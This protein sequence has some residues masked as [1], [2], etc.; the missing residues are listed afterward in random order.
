GGVGDAVGAQGVEEDLVVASQLNIV[1]AGPVAQRVVGEVQD[2]VGLMVGQVELEQVEPLVDGLSEAEVPHEPLD[3]GGGAAGDR[4]G[5]VGDLVVDVGGGEDGVGRGSG[6][7]PVEP[8]AEFP[9]AGGVV[10]VWNRFHSKS[11]WGRA[12]GSV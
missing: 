5:L 7:G 4:P 12:M 6:D 2:M 10:S 9:L 3:G 8:A 11:P 1:E